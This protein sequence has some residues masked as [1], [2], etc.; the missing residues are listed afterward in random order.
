ME[1][2]AVKITHLS[3]ASVPFQGQI[4]PGRDKVGRPN[5]AP[6]CFPYQASRILWVQTCS[7]QS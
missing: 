6:L 4:S 7:F 1:D 5:L 3:L 2:R